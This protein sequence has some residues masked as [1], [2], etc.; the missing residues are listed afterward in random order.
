M[1][2]GGRRKARRAPGLK[3]TNGHLI[4]EQTDKPPLDRQTEEWTD[5]QKT[6]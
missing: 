5:R 1:G 2:G 4:Q 6:F 3:R